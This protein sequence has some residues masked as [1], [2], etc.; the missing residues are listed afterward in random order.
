MRLDNVSVRDTCTRSVWPCSN[1][2]DKE[3]ESGSEAGSSIYISGTRSCEAEHVSSQ[4]PAATTE[5]VPQTHTR[6]R[7]CLTVHS[8]ITVVQS[9][10]HRLAHLSCFSPIRKKL[11]ITLTKMHW[12]LGRK[13][14]LSTSNKLLIHKTILKPIWAY[15]IQLWGTASTSNKKILERSQSKSLGIIV[16]ASWYVPKNG[17]ERF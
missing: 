1:F 10:A 17:A 13:S 4:H 16:D 7:I 9:H 2:N 5:R 15:R 8:R 11:G 12:L 3:G 6:L 14:K